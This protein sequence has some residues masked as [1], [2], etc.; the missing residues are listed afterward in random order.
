MSPTRPPG[1]GEPT[2]KNPAEILRQSEYHQRFL[3]RTM[4][5]RTDDLARRMLADEW[6]YLAALMNVPVERAHVLDLACGSGLHALAWAERGARVTGIDFDHALLEAS[7]TRLERGAP[8]APPA[9]W[10]SGDATRMPFREASFDVVFCNSLLEHVPAWDRV[11]SESARVLKPGGLYVVYTT[12]RSCPYQVEVNDFP[13]YSWLPG[14][15]QR[16]VLAWI[17]EHRRDMVNW[18]DFPAV[19]WFTFPGLSRAFER[20][21]I[22]PY[23]RLD[24]LAR[25]GGTDRRAR[26]A[27]VVTR[28]PGLKWGYYLYAISMALY[29]VKR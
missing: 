17:M 5:A 20:A 1:E 18:T 23:D 10:V 26:I 8:G 2:P 14:P 12:N 28:V 29:G 25:N 11:V 22:R 3:E 24:V 9:R 4:S 27:R 15:I 7:R 19:N 13:F 21:G 6:H 16:R